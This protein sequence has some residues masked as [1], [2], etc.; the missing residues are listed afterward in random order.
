MAKRYATLRRV[1]NDHKISKDTDYEFL[2]QLQNSLLLAL[3]E[4]GRLNAMQY[5]NAE[6]KLKRQRRERAKKIQQIGE[7]Q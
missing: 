7:G 6:E 5:R 1:D 4:Q 2:Y 3:K